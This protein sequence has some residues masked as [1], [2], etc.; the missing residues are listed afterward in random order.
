MRSDI[1]YRPHWSQADNRCIKNAQ[2]N[3]SPVYKT[4]IFRVR[5]MW[6]FFF[7]TIITSTMIPASNIINARPKAVAII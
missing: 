3:T 6:H 1:R 5:K 4:F 7:C 2:T